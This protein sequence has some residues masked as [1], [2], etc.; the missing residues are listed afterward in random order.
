MRRV[1][2]DYKRLDREI[3]AQLIDLYPHGYGDDDI[4]VLKKPNGE[5]IEAVEVRTDDTIFLVKISQSLSN[6]IS[7]FEEN[8]EKE[9][10]NV[11]E[12][13]RLAKESVDEITAL[14]TDSDIDLIE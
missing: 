5:L 3:A 12:E 1:I 8:L 9:L 11:G 7:N 4:I 6:F 2:V 10:G 13:G 14:E